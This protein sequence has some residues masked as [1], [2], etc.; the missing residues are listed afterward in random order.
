MN[1]AEAIEEEGFFDKARRGWIK[2]Q[3]EWG[4]FGELPIEHSTGVKLQLGDEDEAGKRSQPTAG[5]SSTRCRPACATR[6][7]REKRA[8]LTPEEQAALDTPPEK[9]TP[10]QTGIGL[11]SCRQRS[12]SPIAKWPSESPRTSRRRRSRRCNWRARSNARTSGCGTRS[13]TSAT[14]TTTTGRRG[15]SSSRRPTRSPPAKRC[16]SARGRSARAIR[17]APR[18]CTKKASPSGGR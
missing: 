13:I 1:Y 5:R 10:E 11:R 18:S 2:A 16:S 14:A 3:E 4:E 12:T 7:R 6:L 8:A 15:P 9:R 17:S